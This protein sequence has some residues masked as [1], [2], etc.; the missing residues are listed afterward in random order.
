VDAY[1]ARSA[2]FARPILTTLREVVH[3]ACPEVEETLKWGMPSFVHHGILCGMAAFKQHATFGF[4]K[5]PLIL[6]EKGER[7]DEAM[8]QFGRLAS[9]ADL[10]PRKILAGYVKKAAEL[11]EKGVKVPRAPKPKKPALR[12]PASFKTALARNQRASAAFEAFSPSHRRE[13]VEWI[14][15]A[16]TDETR[17]KRI[18]TALE[19]IAQGKSR[20]WKYERPRAKPTAV[21]NRAGSARRAGGTRRAGV[22]ATGAATRSGRRG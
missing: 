5:S 14:G 17:E 1:I 7:A 18:A 21:A 4:W 19:W 12:V 22:R 2:P 13:Y 16:K 6:N 11:N 3:E 9:V 20:Q 15:E 8:G 10:P